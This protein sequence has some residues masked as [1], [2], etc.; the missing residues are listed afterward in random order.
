MPAARQDAPGAPETSGRHHHGPSPDRRPTARSGRRT[1]RIRLGEPGRLAM[2]RQ[3]RPRECAIAALSTSRDIP[4]RSAAHVAGAEGKVSAAG[5]TPASRKRLPVSPARTPQSRRYRARPRHHRPASPAAKPPVRR[6][7]GRIALDGHH[8]TARAPI[9]ALRPAQARRRG[10]D[11]G[12]LA[13]KPETASGID[14]R[15]ERGCAAG[16]RPRAESPPARAP[17]AASVRGRR[18]FTHGPP[19]QRA[20]PL[21]CMGGIVGARRCR[22][23]PCALE[24]ARSTSRRELAPAH[25]RARAW[26]AHVEP[27]PEGRPRDSALTGGRRAGRGSPAPDRWSTRPAVFRRWMGV[28]VDGAISHTGAR[29]NA[30]D[31]SGVWG[32]SARVDAASRRA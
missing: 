10:F 5:R 6:P 2:P 4:P 26:L 27:E 20:D 29:R 30:R 21:G 28:S 31:R 3:A 32:G 1:D 16:G 24:P 8:H 17:P 25:R 15:R 13:P 22:R 12:R 9:G 18:D 19:A 14:D 7:T 11:S 23:A